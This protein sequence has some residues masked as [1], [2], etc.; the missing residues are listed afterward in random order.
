ME[1]AVFPVLAVAVASLLIWGGVKFAGRQPGKQSPAGAKALRFLAFGN[2]VGTG[3][4]LVAFVVSFGSVYGPADEA[5]PFAVGS[6][7]AGLVLL[8]LGNTKLRIH[9][10]EEAL[11]EMR[12]RLGVPETDEPFGRQSETDAPAFDGPSG[13]RPGDLTEPPEHA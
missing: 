9:A 1:D 12:D 8:W 11:A 2:F 13:W 4:A 6:L 10:L 7:L 3:Y 5:L